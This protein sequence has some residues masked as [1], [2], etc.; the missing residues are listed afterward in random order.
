MASACDYFLKFFFKFYIKKNY[1]FSLCESDEH[2]DNTRRFDDPDILPAFHR[3]ANP[4]YEA[5]S[6]NLKVIYS[7]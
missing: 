2:S 1:F 4:R 5:N 3:F 7:S 6:Q